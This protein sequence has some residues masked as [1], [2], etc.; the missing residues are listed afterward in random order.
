MTRIVTYAHRY[1]RPPKRKPVTIE[2]PAIVRKQA[3]ADVTRP[4]PADEP[5][6]TND[7]R[8]LPPPGARKSAI[9]T[10][11][12]KKR[13]DQ[14]PDATGSPAASVQSPSS[15]PRKP[16]IVTSISRRQTRLQRAEQQTEDPDAPDAPE[17]EDFEAE[18]A[19]WRRIL[20]Q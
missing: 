8:K 9:V 16:A 7:D 1:K 11:R 20:S 17:P 3:R 12:S 13:V 14:S 4:K 19:R 5:T 18:T 10:I 2:G 15:E 6:P